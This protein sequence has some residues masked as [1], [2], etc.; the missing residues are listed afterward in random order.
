MVREALILALLQGIEAVEFEVPVGVVL[1]AVVVAAL[2][3]LVVVVVAAAG[4]RESRF[5][6]AEA[7]VAWQSC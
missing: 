5:V 7:A 2:R 1:A 6:V 3:R 4:V